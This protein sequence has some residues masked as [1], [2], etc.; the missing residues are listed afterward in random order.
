MKNSMKIIIALL[1]ASSL[2]LSAQIAYQGR[3]T[4]DTG[5]PLS[6]GPKTIRFDLYP[7]ATG[8]SSAWNETLLV[9]T[10]DGRFS[11]TLGLVD[12]SINEEIK[13]NI[14]LELTVGGGALSPRQQILASP[15]SLHALHADT[16]TS[17]TS[18]TNATSAT[19]ADFATEAGFA[20]TLNGTAWN[21]PGTAQINIS[22]TNRLQIAA[23][24][25]TSNGPAT[26]NGNLTQTGAT[27][28]NGTCVISS[29][30]PN[31]LT[32]TTPH[33]ATNFRRPLEIRSNLGALLFGYQLDRNGGG[34]GTG[35]VVSI[36]TAYK[37]GGGSF[38]ATSDARLKKNVKNLHGSLDRL[39]QL[40]PVTFEFNNEERHGVTG[41]QTGFIAQ[42]VEEVFP[43]GIRQ[44]ENTAPLNDGE[45]PE[46]EN[47]KTI[48][49]TGFEALTVD[50][51]RELRAEKNAEIA[52]LRNTNHA[53]ETRI[54]N[55]ESKLTTLMS[56]LDV[57]ENDKGKKISQ[58]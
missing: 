22:G 50:A 44:R 19:T 46:P 43:D 36:G 53:L 57:N 18:A 8:G 17:A 28:L 55:L 37:P 9:N 39:E 16:A 20:N 15:R 3:L 12:S 51:F 35:L 21:S 41:V 58:K 1:G 29:T 4:D 48:S 42:E 23:T 38:A 49:I 13:T 11:T 5:A 7:T 6:N 30:L 40:R 25:I 27:N 31:T 45:T 52:K 32:L 2:I 34:A 26:I 33:E 14:Y 24:G 47:I 56:A 10:I 54:S